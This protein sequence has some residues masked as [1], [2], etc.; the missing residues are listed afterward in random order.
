MK[1]NEVDPLV[2]CLLAMARFNDIT[3]SEESVTSGL[4]LVDGK[5]TPS[6]FNRAAARLNLTSN[7]V[8]MPLDQL[9][10][11]HYLPVILINDSGSACVLTGWNDAGTMA[12]VILPELNTAATDIPLDQLASRYTG[13]AIMVKPIFQ[14]DQSM[15]KR[16]N[17]EDGHWFW[18]AI[19]ANKVVYRDVLLAAFFINIF[20]L[21]LPIFTMNVYDRVV[22]NHAMETLWMLAT[23]VVLIMLTDAILKTVRAYFLDLAGRRVDIQ[24]SAKIMERVLGLRLEAKPNSVGSFAS[25]LRSFESVRDFITSASITT[26]IDLPFS[27]IFIFVIG[28]I[29]WPM[30][31]PVLV[32][33]M[34]VLAYALATQARLKTLTETV[35]VAGAMRNSTLVES[36]VGLETLKTMGAEGTMQRKWEKSTNFLARVGVQLRLL[37][38]ATAS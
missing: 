26:L 30:I 31:I 5:L 10:A 21:A 1:P 11:Q 23:G 3:A 22:P 36:L 28:W 27:L 34:I 14:F 8:S 20:A 35:Y 38:T 19:K 9:K 15:T 12:K 7:M 2:Q 32:A 25:N 33:V 37:S 16:G 29:A 17:E 24:L 6:L 4:P 13:S 18:S